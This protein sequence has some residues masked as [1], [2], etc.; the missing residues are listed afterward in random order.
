MKEQLGIYQL[1][2]INHLITLSV[3]RLSG[4]ANISIMVYRVEVQFCTSSPSSPAAGK[5]QGRARRI[6][7]SRPLQLQS[8]IEKLRFYRKH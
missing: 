3:I 2:Y 6:S 8:E 4:P 5:R 7:Q 1:D